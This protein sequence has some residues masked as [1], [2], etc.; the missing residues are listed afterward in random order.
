DKKME[1]S[2]NSSHTKLF[3]KISGIAEKTKNI[4][5]EIEDICKAHKNSWIAV[6]HA[7]GNGL[8][9]ILRVMGDKLKEGDFE[10][11]K[12]AFRAFSRALDKATQGAARTAFNKVFSK[13]EAF[14]SKGMYPI[15]PIICGGDDIT[16]IIRADLALE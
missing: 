10:K 9:N 7:D 15:R 2:N 14:T 4:P 16:F 13:E 3:K 8:G 1:G 6:V 12:S 5:L 11:S